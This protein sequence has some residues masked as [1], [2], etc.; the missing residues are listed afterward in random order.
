MAALATALTEFSDNGD[1]RTYTISGHSATKPKL[2][3]QKRKV[4]VGNQVMAE[5]SGTV[6]YGVLAGDGSVATN[7]VSQGVFARYPVDADP[8]DLAAMNAAALVI[9]RD[10]VASDEFGAA[11]T[12]QAWVE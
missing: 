3:V 4:P 10:F 8:T 12:S 2:V 6:V 1:S 9:L 7:K 5:F 11:V